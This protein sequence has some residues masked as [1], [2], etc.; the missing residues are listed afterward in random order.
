MTSRKPLLSLSESS[1]SSSPEQ[2]SK[3]S[4]NNNIT[5]AATAASPVPS[6]DPRPRRISHDRLLNA[7]EL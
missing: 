1:S 2:S 3:S 7:W 6:N 5:A 4:T